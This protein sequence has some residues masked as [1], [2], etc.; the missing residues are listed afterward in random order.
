MKYW[1]GPKY[2][3]Q[4]FG[5][6]MCHTLQ[7]SSVHISKIQFQII[8]ILNMYAWL[9]KTSDVVCILNMY[10][11]PATVSIRS[12]QEYMS[13]SRTMRC[14]PSV[15]SNLQDILAGC[16]F[17]A[18]RVVSYDGLLLLRWSSDNRWT[19]IYKHAQERV[20][21]VSLNWRRENKQAQPQ[22]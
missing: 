12:L 18:L 15:V 5:D 13:I 8:C 21:N 7:I 17:A 3:R 9:P 19:N 11:W 14:G 10:A 4:Y 1:R 22:I 16:P 20:Q 6:Y 2:H